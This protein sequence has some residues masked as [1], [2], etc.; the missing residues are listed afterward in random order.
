MADSR[1]DDT[2]SEGLISTP[3]KGLQPVKERIGI[4][5]RSNMTKFIGHTPLVF[6]NNVTQRCNAAV[7]VLEV[8]QHQSGP[9]ICF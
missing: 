1:E 9:K 3:T 7:C 2:I 4:N 5:A 6:I 8:T